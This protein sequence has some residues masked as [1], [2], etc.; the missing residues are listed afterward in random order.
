[1]NGSKSH[2][3]TMTLKNGDISYAPYRIIVN[4]GDQIE[5]ECIGKKGVKYHVAVH[6]GWDSPLNKGR[7]R[8]LPGKKVSGVVLDEAKHG[9]YKYFVAIS[10][11]KNIWTDDPEIIVRR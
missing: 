1:M 11:G 10:D 3:V 7:I 5:W 8:A 2:K 4:R 6:V 9:T